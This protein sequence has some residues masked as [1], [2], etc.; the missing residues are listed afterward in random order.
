MGLGVQVYQRDHLYIPGPLSL[1]TFPHSP[2]VLPHVCDYIF[3]EIWEGTIEIIAT[4]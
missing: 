4:L 2:H 3:T 1:Y